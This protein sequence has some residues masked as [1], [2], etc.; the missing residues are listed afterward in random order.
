[1]IKLFFLCLSIFFLVFSLLQHKQLI[2]TSSEEK[3]FTID[4]TQ[5]RDAQINAIVA[6]LSSVTGQAVGI[7]L[8]AS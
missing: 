8:L 3:I 5:D 6:Y 7:D 4:M 2:H 1:M